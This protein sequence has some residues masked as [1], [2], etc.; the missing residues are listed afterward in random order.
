MQA[1]NRKKTWVR[2]DLFLPIKT[3]DFMTRRSCLLVGG[4]CK[5]NLSAFKPSACLPEQAAASPAI[6]KPDPSQGH[7]AVAKMLA[8]SDVP[9]AAIGSPSPLHPS[10][11]YTLAFLQNT[12]SKKRRELILQVSTWS[13]FFLMSYKPTNWWFI[14]ERQTD[15]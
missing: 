1:S 8:P 10:G 6:T 9:I 15:I 12:F 14:I 11:S 5:F 2:K 3:P 13:K 7:P 4:Y